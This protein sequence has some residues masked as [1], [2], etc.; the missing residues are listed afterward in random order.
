MIPLRRRFGEAA[1]RWYS[2]SY[3]ALKSMA[4][5]AVFG[6]LFIV[7]FLPLVVDNGLFF[8]FITSKG[9]ALR[10]LVEVGFGAYVLLALADK[11]YRPRFSWT[12]ALYAAFVLW[13]FIADFFAANPHKAFWSNYERMD[14]W[15]TMIHVFLFFLMAGAVL[16]AEKL[17]K[18]WWLTVLAA[19]ALVAV[20]GLWQMFGLAQIHQGGARADASF[21]NAIYL[22]VYLMFTVL[23]A[24]WQ[25]IESK[26]WLRY[27]LLALAALQVVIIFA[28]ATR[29][30]ILGLFFAAGVVAVA[31]AAKSGGTGKKVAIGAVIALL[32]L[33]GGFFLLRDSALVRNE[34]TLT[35]IATIFDSGELKVRE[36]LWGMAYQG[37]L[38]RPITGWGQEGYNY[39]F[40]KYYQ[41]SL[42]GQEAWFDRAHNT[43]LDWLVAGGAPALL[44]F[45]ALLVSA[46]LAL[47][48]SDAGRAEKFILIG[49]LAGYAL[50][51][52]S[53]FDNLF[54][55]L[56]LAAVL[57]V[58]H[59]R[60]ARPIAYFERMPETGAA[61][62]GTVA[63]PLAMVATVA[64]LWI[65]NVPGLE[66]AGDLI[67]GAELAGTPATALTQ[68]QN[69]VARGSFA[70][71][72]VAEQ[73]LT[74]ASAIGQQASVPLATRQGA[75][76]LALTAMQKEVAAAPNDARIRLMYAQGLAAAGDTAGYQQEMQA[77][78]ALSP[79][80]Q[81]ILFQKGIAEWQ[82][83]DRAGAAKDFAAGY[84][85]DTSFSSAAEY[86]AIG[87]LITGDIAGGKALLTGAF[88]TTTIDDDLMRYAYYDAKLYGDL[89]DTA[90]LHVANNPDDPNAHFLLAQAYAVAGRFAD[91]R[92]E[93]QATIAAHPDAATA[94]AA[95]LQQLGQK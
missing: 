57:A 36:T 59:E 67:R 45:L 43:Y 73:A 62:L 58:A 16:S 88:G 9:F 69:A 83:G 8:P 19:S 75:F 27:A 15:V 5:W 71:Q 61:T 30:A 12:S 50:Q 2:L 4:R 93:V 84:E 22:A 6:V 14:G 78:L 77:A 68:Y 82:A 47:F 48:R 54:S 41:P 7:P 95:L 56:L 24:L 23:L 85:L 33:A 26:G 35:R 66:A 87:K 74:F 64:V 51:A 18:R 49:V 94:G 70:S 29:G 92:A 72:E 17:W 34:P 37:F 90:K 39:V 21:G 60:S 46:V 3:M 10:I 25:A 53:A 91:A 80:K 20:Y 81:G 86:A 31:W 63:A 65:V 55:Y 79:K 42:F 40:N 38:E 28:T 89:V 44:L 13:M 52:V 76:T 32:A 11:R 1:S